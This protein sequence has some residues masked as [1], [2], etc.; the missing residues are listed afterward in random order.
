M[1]KRLLKGAQREVADGLTSVIDVSA[2]GV[3]TL[4]CHQITASQLQDPSSKGVSKQ[5]F[6]PF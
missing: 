5:R 2:K 3:L 4:N 6:F 1:S